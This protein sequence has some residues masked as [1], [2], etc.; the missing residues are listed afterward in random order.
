ATGPR[1]GLSVWAG[2]G[3]GARYRLPPAGATVGTGRVAIQLTEDPFLSTHHVTF[4][5]REGVLYV[6]DEG[7]ASGTYVTISGQEVLLPGTWFSAGPRLFRYVGPLPP[8]S[9]APAGGTLVYG[10]PLP[11]GQS[12]SLIEEVMMGGRPGR[13]LVTVGPLVTIGAAP[14]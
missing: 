12:L 13:A 2:K 4:L 6:R 3:R 9:L 5:V 11:T 14:G 1:F 10:A 8:P 7:T